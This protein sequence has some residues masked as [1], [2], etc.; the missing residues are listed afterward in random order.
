MPNMSDSPVSNRPPALT[1]RWI[2][3]TGR[4]WAGGFDVFIET[5]WGK[6]NWIYRI[7]NGLKLDW[8]IDL[9][10]KFLSVASCILFFFGF[11]FLNV[12]RNCVPTLSTLNSQLLHAAE[13]MHEMQMRAL[14]EEEEILKQKPQSQR[15]TTVTWVHLSHMTTSIHATQIFLEFSPL[16][17]ED[18][19]FWRSYFSK[20]LKP[21]TSKVGWCFWGVKYPNYPPQG[22]SPPCAIPIY[23]NRINHP[24]PNPLDSPMKVAPPSTL[25][26]TSGEPSETL[27]VGYFEK[28]SCQPN[29]Y[30]PQ[31]TNMTGWKIH[32]LKM[33]FLL[34]MGIF[35]C[36][37]S[38]QGC[39]GAIDLAELSICQSLT[40]GDFFLTVDFFQVWCN[41]VLP[42]RLFSVFHPWIQVGEWSAISWMWP[43]PRMPVTT[44]IITF[45][46][47]NP[48]KP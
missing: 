18:S 25:V 29:S 26:T 3:E 7:Q 5:V 41:L 14:E 33:Y 9:W 27:K 48:Y 10:W 16:F 46:I 21:P 2:Q 23:R 1:Q 34:K 13:E 32:H 12:A 17:G 35:Q 20:G 47:G 15:S 40:P 4:F 28:K 43:P 38:F 19:H 11:L 30:T 8:R 24:T 44:R 42:S 37:V 22:L 45:L 36:H 39:I 31:K 6:T